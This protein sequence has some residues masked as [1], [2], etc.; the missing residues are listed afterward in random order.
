MLAGRRDSTSGAH[1]SIWTKSAETPKYPM[2]GHDIRVD[3]CV[4]GA[5][6][7][8][9]SVAHALAREK[10]SV[11]V[12]DD[13]AIGS[14]ETGRTTAHLAS[15]VDD[16][17]HILEGIHGAE[18]ARHVA[19]SHIAAI[20]RIEAI[21]REEGIECGFERVD[22][23]LF[24]Q[25]GESED[26][27]R[28]EH[29]AALRAGLTCYLAERAPIPAFDTGLCLRFP[30]QA[31]FHPLRYLAGLAEAAVRHGAALYTGGHAVE[32]TGGR[33]AC[34]TLHSGK[35]I[36]AAHIV[37]ATNVPV[38]DRLA[39]H[40]KLEPHRTYVI[41]AD[42]P[43]GVVPRGLLWDT[44]DPY[45]Y[46]RTV[47]DADGDP[48]REILLVGGEDHPT[49]QADDFDRR[50][51]DLEAWMRGRWPQAGEVRVRWS[52]Q[53]I[54]TIDGIAYIGRNP[55]VDDNVYIVTGDSGN[56]LTHG[57][58]AG[59]LIPDLILKRENPWAETYR[60]GRLPVKAVGELN[61]RNLRAAVRY[62]DWIKGGAE[63]GQELDPGQGAVVR[64]GLRPVAVYKDM[65]GKVHCMSAIC[66]HLK[67][68]VGWNASE[69]TWDCPC[70]GS[71]FDRRGH[72]INGPANRDLT[73]L[74]EPE[75]QE[76]EPGSG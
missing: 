19:E 5:G 15:A 52:G 13:G 23:W 41:A 48:D 22:G 46:V 33:D 49:G 61:R 20:D 25:P 18:A 30:H 66:P 36:H 51:A 9:L 8:G 1:V 44:E 39:M 76:V 73:H 14:G 34:V 63:D 27:I 2:L 42:I 26:I 35:R 38:N 40:T 70:H 11:A 69:E 71:R 56:G 37:V 12:V 6:I 60:P 68:V 7:A 67:C 54:E 75:H 17:Y 55:G 4:V 45:H 74:Y 31:Q 3:V 43:R 57:T 65:E 28:R 47:R 24:R 53:I 32:I 29:E 64:H 16:H 62:A 10:V 59:M 50:Y 21:A 58:I 72:V